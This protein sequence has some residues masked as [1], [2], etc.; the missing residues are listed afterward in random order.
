MGL[1]QVA[2]R[3]DR[4]GGARQQEFDH[5][6][7]DA[8]GVFRVGA[9]N[10]RHLEAVELGGLRIGLLQG[11][12]RRYDQRQLVAEPLFDGIF[13]Q[14]DVAPVNRVERPEVEHHPFHLSRR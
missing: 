7:L 14:S 3:V 9:G 6:G 2:Q 12:L 8:V 11:V 10:L 5:R 1:A 4:I 13:G